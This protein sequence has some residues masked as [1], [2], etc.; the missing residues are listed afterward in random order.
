MI[1]EIKKRNVEGSADWIDYVMVY[2]TSRLGRNTDENH[3]L[4]KLVT[5]DELF[6]IYSI[7]EDYGP[8]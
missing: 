2:M 8:E 7:K 3:E 1:E 5:E 4:V 6:Q